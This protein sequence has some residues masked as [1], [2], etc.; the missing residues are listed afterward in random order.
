MRIAIIAS[1]YLP[2]PPTK[3]GG[4]ERVIDF[5]I[6]GLQELD[7]EVILFASGDSQVTCELIPICEKSLPFAKNAEEDAKFQPLREAAARK[8]AEELRKNLHRIDIIHTHGVAIKPSD[9]DITQFKDFPNVTTLH[10]PIILQNMEYFENHKDFYYIT[11]SNNQQ[12]TF[13]DLK[14]V[15]TVY[16]GL[17][18]APF[19]VN[20]TPED[21]LCFLGRFDRDKNPHLAIHLALKL[22]MKLKMAGK[23]D[24][25]GNDFFDQE[26]KPHLDNPLIEYLG[27]LGFEDKATL[28]ANAKCNLHPTGFREPFGLSVLE[29]AYCGTPTMAISRGS[30]PEL[31]EEN[32]TGI[33][34]EDFDAGYHQIQKCFEMDRNYI[35]QRAR[36]LFNYKTMAKQYVL[37]YEK[38]IE[39]YKSEAGSKHEESKVLEDVKRGLQGLW[40][41]LI[42]R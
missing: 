33:L 26:V 37:A 11:I 16:N 7:H 14:Y 20:E 42:N 21:Y 40:E 24:L 28:I 38:V 27:E 17:D 19:K 23:I 34:V 2:I 32:R 4:T 29:A 30:M 12:E 35:A 39:L 6:K 3:Y 1:P 8:T 36:L 13:P 10:G 31:I 22:G 18:P 41:S 25:A 9:L 5:V 15:G